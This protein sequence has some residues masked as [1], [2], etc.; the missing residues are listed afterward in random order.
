MAFFG[1]IRCNMML[2]IIFERGLIMFSFQSVGICMNEM[3]D[4][5]TGQ[6]KIS[7]ST[8][9]QSYHQG[10]GVFDPETVRRKHPRLTV[11][12]GM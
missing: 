3:T 6:H 10:S 2:A 5:D 8:F 1:M 7:S 9:E 12:N 4:K 11:I